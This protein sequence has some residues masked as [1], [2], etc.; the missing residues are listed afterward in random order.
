M[1][2]NTMTYD[3]EDGVGPVPAH[4]HSRGRGWVANTARVESSAYIGPN[5]KVFG[6]AWVFGNAVVRGN[7]RVYGNAWVFG[8]AKHLAA[9]Y[10]VRVTNFF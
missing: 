8:T 5:A 4:Q 9:V 7:A 3:F 1:K 6:N 2:N 10:A